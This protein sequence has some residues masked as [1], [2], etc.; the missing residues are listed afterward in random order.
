MKFLTY[1]VPQNSTELPIA[2]IIYMYIYNVNIDI[3]MI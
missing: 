3:T 1:S 2:V